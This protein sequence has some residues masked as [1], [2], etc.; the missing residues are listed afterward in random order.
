MIDLMKDLELVRSLPDGSIQVTPK[1]SVSLSSED[2]FERQIRSSVKSLFEKKQIPFS[3]INQTISGI[4][5]PDVPN[6]DTIFEALP[7]DN[8]HIDRETFRK[9]MYLLACSDG[10]DRSIKVLYAR[11]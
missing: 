6:P 11:V 8:P 5:L 2:G 7:G 9:L 1:G 3:I 4:S 10:I